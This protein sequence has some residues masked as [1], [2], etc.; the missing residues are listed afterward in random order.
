M[1]TSSPTPKGQGFI[2]MTNN[3]GR[4]LEEHYA[5]RGNS[6]TFAGKYY[7]YGLIYYEEFQYVTDAIAREKE[8]KGWGR[9]K[10]RRTDSNKKSGYDILEPLILYSLATK[11]SCQWILNVTGAKSLR[12]LVP[13]H[14]KLRDEKFFFDH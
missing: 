2:G 8:L 5:N 14:D 7:C 10:K 4:R 11:E 9:K 6:K 13:R 3:L 12:C 1:S